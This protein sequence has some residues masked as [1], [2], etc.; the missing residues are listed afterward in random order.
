MG[1]IKYIGESGHGF[2][3]PFY[4]HIPIWCVVDCTLQ[5]DVELK[6]LG[7]IFGLVHNYW[8]NEEFTT[9]SV[10]YKYFSP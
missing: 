1:G 3:P 8:W 5:W 6:I 7:L 4:I 2:K 10:K 9:I